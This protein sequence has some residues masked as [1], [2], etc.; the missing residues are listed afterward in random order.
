MDDA[1]L[2]WRQ[3]TAGS[4]MKRGSPLSDN[5]EKEEEREGKKK[6]RSS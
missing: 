1:V 4:A 6:Q 3:R 2:Q 5:K